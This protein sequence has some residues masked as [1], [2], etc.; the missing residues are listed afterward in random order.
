[1]L[2]LAMRIGSRQLGDT[3][4]QE[5]FVLGARAGCQQSPAKRSSPFRAPTIASI[6]GARGWH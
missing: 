3:D 2:E 4:S 6:P 1:M 5:A